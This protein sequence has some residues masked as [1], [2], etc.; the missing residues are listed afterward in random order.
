MEAKDVMLH[1]VLNELV[2]AWAEL[3]TPAEIRQDRKKVQLLNQLRATMEG[4]PSQLV[5]Q[6]YREVFLRDVWSGVGS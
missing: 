1:E 5:Q 6:F 3:F 4:T 2:R